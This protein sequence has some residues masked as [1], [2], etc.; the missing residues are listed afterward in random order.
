MEGK[1]E[2]SYHAA[3]DYLRITYTRSDASDIALTHYQGAVR[4]VSDTYGYQEESPKAWSWQ[5]YK[6]AQ[7]GAACWGLREDGCIF[8]VSGEAASYAALLDLPYTGVPRLDI[9]VTT[10]GQVAPYAQPELVALASEKARA[11]CSHRPWSIQLVRGFGGGDTCYLGSRSSAWFVRVYDKERESGEAQYETAVRYEVEAHDEEA[12]ALWDKVGG[13]DLPKEVLAGLV[14]GYL[15]KRGYDLSGLLQVATGTP[16]WVP[17]AKTSTARTLQWLGEGVAPTCARLNRA[18]VS[19]EALRGLLGLSEPSRR[20]PKM[21]RFR[22]VKR[23]TPPVDWTSWESSGR[24][25]SSDE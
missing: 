13:R 14:G 15:G 18:G 3:I 19:Q 9:Q 17:R 24:M 20:R 25:P 8:Q 21:G 10:W 7:Q 11:V 22:S 23:E 16:P 6:G 1:R 5:G 2:V 12:M 4:L